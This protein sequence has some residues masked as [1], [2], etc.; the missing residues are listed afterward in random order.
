[1]CGQLWAFLKSK[2]RYICQEIDEQWDTFRAQSQDVGAE[3]GGGARAVWKRKEKVVV[4]KFWGFL[5]NWSVI[6]FDLY[7]G[8]K[9]KSTDSLV[10]I[11]PYPLTW[12]DRTRQN[13]DLSLIEVG[14]LFFLTGYMDC[15]VWCR[16]PTTMGPND[17]QDL[18]TDGFWFLSKCFISLIF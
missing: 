7:V 2:I 13:P 11:N 9:S 10:L 5:L 4:I 12:K 3:S 6:T 1:M 18:Q 8:V 14:G 15:K 16:H 17:L